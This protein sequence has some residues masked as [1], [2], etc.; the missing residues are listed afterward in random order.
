MKLLRRHGLLVV[1]GDCL[2]SLIR[3]I[4]DNVQLKDGTFHEDVGVGTSEMRSKDSAIQ[5]AM[6]EAVTDGRKRA[7]KNFGNLLGT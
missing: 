2:N 3:S 6:K 4:C 7:L 1:A 5:K